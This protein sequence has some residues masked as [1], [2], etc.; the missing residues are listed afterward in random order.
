MSS[1]RIETWE[2]FWP[3]YVR[4]HN[5]PVCRV[6]HFVGST[7]VLALLGWVLYSQQ[8]LYLIALPFVGYGFA[9]V[10]HFGIEKNRP[11]SFSYPLW[12]FMADWKMWAYML[13][14]RMGGEVQRANS[15]VAK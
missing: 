8:W 14:G 7:L 15:V 5:H 4:E 6:L 1:Q 13:V 11:A 12:S 3:F 10:G 9:W 2:E